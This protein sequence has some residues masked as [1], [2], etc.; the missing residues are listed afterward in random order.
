MENRDLAEEA[1][2][3]PSL[4]FFWLE[5]WKSVVYASMDLW[6]SLKLR[7]GKTMQ[8]CGLLYHSVPRCIL[9]VLLLRICNFLIVTSAT[10]AVK[11]VGY[12]S[13]HSTLSD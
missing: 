9:L 11:C 7:Q 8:A 2:P 12:T 1:P 3:P 13:M 4:N 10:Q 5:P 6:F